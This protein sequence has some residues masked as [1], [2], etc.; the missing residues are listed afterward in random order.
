MELLYSDGARTLQS[1]WATVGL[2]SYALLDLRAG[3]NIRLVQNTSQSLMKP[4][5]C[6][7]WS[8]M[9]RA[10]NVCFAW[11]GRF[12]HCRDFQDLT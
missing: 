1:S 8:E 7:T 6:G 11:K 2:R 5:G 4:P 12:A 3:Q 10:V 9:L